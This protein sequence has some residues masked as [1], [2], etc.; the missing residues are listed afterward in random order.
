MSTP[1][2]STYVKSRSVEREQQMQTAF[3]AKVLEWNSALGVV[4]LEPQFVETWVTQDGRRLHETLE[5][6]EYAYI[7]NVPVMYPRSGRW[8]VTFPIEPDSFGLVLCTKYSLD[9][10]RNEGRRMDP[11]DLRRFTMSGAVFHPVNMYPDDTTISLQH[12][13]NQLSTS[14]MVLG[15]VSPL[16][17]FVALA[18]KVKDALD[19]VK[20]HTH[21]GV[22]SGTGSS[23][24]SSELSA[25]QTGTGSTSVKVSP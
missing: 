19:L 11:G 15:K 21:T 4:K 16:S 25:M 23:G 13:P 10:W 6:P 22:T 1:L 7:E 17:D 5:R 12:T 8:S 14:V 18:A 3:P 20:N 2:L 24:T 9:Q